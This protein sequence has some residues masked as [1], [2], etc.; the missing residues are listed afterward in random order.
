VSCPECLSDDVEVIAFDFGICSQTGYRDAGERFHC[1]ECGTQGDADEMR[2]P[3]CG[4]EARVL[5]GHRGRRVA[6]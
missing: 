6:M 5:P 2:A 3:P 1:R 4:G